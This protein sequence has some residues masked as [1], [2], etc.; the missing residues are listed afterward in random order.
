MLVR[1]KLTGP[2]SIFEDMRITDRKPGMFTTDPITG[3]SY[4]RPG[5]LQPLYMFELFGLLVALAAYNG[6]TI[7][8]SFPL[9][10][11]KNLL[12]PP[13]TDLRDLQ[14]GWPAIA[15]SLQSIKD[16]AYEGLDYVFPLEANGLRMSVGHS[17][18]RRVRDQCDELKAGKRAALNLVVEEISRIDNPASAASAGAH[19]PY[20]Q[21]WPGWNIYSPE[22]G[23][24]PEAITAIPE[25]SN[26]TSPPTPTTTSSPQPPTPPYT[27]DTVHT[28]L[29]P[30]NI[31]SYTID[32]THWLT[33]LSI[34][35]Q[36]TS[37][38]KGF[39]AL[40]PTHNLA[41]FTP[42][43][44][45]STLEGTSTL[46]LPAL[47][48]STKY[49]NYSP[50]EP[51]IASFWSILSAWPSEKQKALLKFVTAAERIPISG[52]G[53]LTFR[54]QFV[55]GEERLGVVGESEG[56]RVELLPTSST[57]FGTL[58][59]PR[60]KDEETLERKLGVALEFGGMGFGTA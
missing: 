18:F 22:T 34:H 47:R 48:A 6:I 23:H 43:T 60:Y 14:D 40:L 29:T 2:R 17:A 46:D 26:P 44:L 1:R 10:L 15:R 28:T 8:V 45:R 33:T 7:P 13:C 53:A 49:K 11:Y 50:D 35:P 41:L 32:Y 20:Y 38:K 5:S 36:L 54:V 27:K 9:A 19:Q 3:L 24:N 59:L 58:Y 42:S 51:Y 4:F 37:F 56:S 16:G 12:G 52:A 30:S 39:H 57:C 25:S 31:N 55:A 21:Q